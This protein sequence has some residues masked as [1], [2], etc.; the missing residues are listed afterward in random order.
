MESIAGKIAV[1]TGGTR[2][3]GRAVAERLL[4][5]GARVAICGRTRESV[6]RAVNSMRQAEGDL[7]GHPADLT[8]LADVTHF[9]QAVDSHFGGLDILVNNAGLGVF[10]KVGELTPE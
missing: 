4:A 1:A 10:R 8:K 3:I 7:F 2:G 9:F 6:D 5:E